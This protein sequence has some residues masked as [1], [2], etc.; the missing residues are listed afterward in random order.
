MESASADEIPYWE[1]INKYLER[2]DP[3]ELQNTVCQLV[4]RLVRSRSFADARIRDKYWQI[5][6]D[7][8]QIHSSRRKL[9]E[10]LLKI[11]MGKKRK[12]RT[13]KERHVTG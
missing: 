12:N 5:I 13:V 9:D 1:T 6:V 4:C 11:R 8:T 7:G 3:K 2:L 10:N